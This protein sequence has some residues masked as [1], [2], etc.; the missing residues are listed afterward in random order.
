MN[1]DNTGFQGKQAILFDKSWI[2]LKKNILRSSSSLK[3]TQL[4]T[5]LRKIQNT[6]MKQTKENK[7]IYFFS[8]HLDEPNLPHFFYY[9]SIEFLTALI[10]AESSPD[11]SL[12]TKESAFKKPSAHKI[13]QHYATILEALNTGEGAIY[14]KNV[15]SQYD[16]FYNTQIASILTVHF[17]KTL[18]QLLLALEAE[19]ISVGELLLHYLPIIENELSH[20]LEDKTRMKKLEETLTNPCVSELETWLTKSKSDLSLDQ[21]IVFELLTHNLL[22]NYLFESNASRELDLN[23]MYEKKFMKHVYEVSSRRKE[24]IEGFQAIPFNTEKIAEYEAHIDDYI[25]NILL[26]AQTKFALETFELH[27][28][29]YPSVKEILAT[30]IQQA[31]TS[32]DIQQIYQ[33]LLNMVLQIKPTSTNFNKERIDRL[34]NIKKR[35]TPKQK[36]AS[37]YQ[38]LNLLTTAEKRA[39]SKGLK[40]EK[41]QRIEAAIAL[42]NSELNALKK[43]LD[44]TKAANE[45]L[46]FSDYQERIYTAHHFF[47]QDSSKYDSALDL[48]IGAFWLEKEK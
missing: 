31:L 32:D 25:E 6:L 45:E 1:V 13:I 48:L 22:G 16:A 41:I 19:S 11:T 36:N 20:I 12:Y 3:N 9:E 42:K 15:L 4:D 37:A 35:K 17:T 7:Q 47:Q 18:N 28:V 46:L 5:G 26:T 27:S 24:L 40:Q 33:Y 21:A 29:D 30:P 2:N 14:N 8:Q 10:K 39:F 23:L 34:N 44:D 38:Q 43:D